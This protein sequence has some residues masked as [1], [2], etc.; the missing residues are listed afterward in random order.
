M[1]NA[2]PTKDRQLTEHFTLFELTKTTMDRYQAE[3]RVIT[4]AQIVKAVELARL[5]EHVRHV[6]NEPL[7]V[8]SGYRCKGL[9][10]AVGSTDASQHIL[11]EAADIVPA[12]MPVPEAFRLLSFDIRNKG[13]NV[14]QLIEETAARPYGVTS[15][16]HISL[17]LPYR[18]KDR[19]RQVLRMKDGKFELLA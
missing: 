3:N 13:T 4:D 12:N 14:G 1:D 10:K 19:N 15:W 11:F 2:R 16:I 17:G 9:N 7:I 6:L 8:S 18:S 5:L